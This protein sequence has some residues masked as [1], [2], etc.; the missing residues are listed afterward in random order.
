MSIFA[1]L[2]DAVSVAQS[3][4]MSPLSSFS[5]DAVDIAVVVIYFVIV[6][7]VGL[8][9]SSASN[10]PVVSKN[11]LICVIILT[12]F[13]NVNVGL[14]MFLCYIV[15]H[16]ISTQ[17]AHVQYSLNY[18][19]LLKALHTVIHLNSHLIIWH[20]IGYNPRHLSSQCCSTLTPLLLMSIF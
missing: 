5:L 20:T 7:V 9:V 10:H 11:H 4:D 17:M 14:F 19:L 6:M 8:W 18:P 12:V 3:A 16:S 15:S 2:T 1:L 13:S